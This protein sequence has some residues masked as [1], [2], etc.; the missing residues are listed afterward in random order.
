MKLSSFE[1]LASAYLFLI[2]SAIADKGL[3]GNTVGD[4]FCLE[5]GQGGERRGAITG[6][7]SPL[8]GLAASGRPQSTEKLLLGSQR[9]GLSARS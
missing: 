4:P 8:E 1:C 3:D 9:L 2:S 5:N 7:C 6:S